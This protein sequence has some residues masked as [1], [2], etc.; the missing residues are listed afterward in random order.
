MCTTKFWFRLEPKRWLPGFGP[1]WM[2]RLGPMWNI[3]RTKMT[4]DRLGSSFLSRYPMHRRHVQT[5]TPVIATNAL[6]SYCLTRAMRALFRPVCE[7]CACRPHP[8]SIR[9]SFPAS[10]ARRGAW[11][12]RSFEQPGLFR[13]SLAGPRQSLPAPGLRPQS[14]LS[15][16]IV[17]PRSLRISSNRFVSR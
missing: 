3:S 9:S 12:P 4:S 5:R 11:S 1:C 2:W 17:H 16:P 6:P 15:S 10:L 7:S 13:T 8:N 14:D